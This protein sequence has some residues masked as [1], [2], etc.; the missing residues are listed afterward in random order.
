MNGLLWVLQVLLAL[1]TAMGAAWKLSNS[2]LLA[3]SLGAIP[4]GGWLVLCVVETLCALV[5]LAPFLKPAMG[6]FAPVASAVIGAEMLLFCGVYLASGQPGAGQMTYWL[7]V[8]AVCAFL[9]YGRWK[10]KPLR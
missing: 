8:A 3:S 4:H 10:L 1:H 7:V 6:R 2:E 9:T 5:L